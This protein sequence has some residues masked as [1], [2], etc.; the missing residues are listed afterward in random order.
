LIK[1]RKFFAGR[2]NYEPEHDS[3]SESQASTI[4]QDIEDVG[5]EPEKSPCPDM[6]LFK[7]IAHPEY[8]RALREPFHPASLPSQEQVASKL[9]QALGR[10]QVRL[11]YLLP[12]SDGSIIE[13][14]LITIPLSDL[15]PIDKTG[16][17][18]L[19]SYEALSYTWGDPRPTK[20]VICNGLLYPIVE[21]LHT[22]LL[23]LRRK[24]QRRVNVG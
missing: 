24:H 22:A 23:S 16:D 1:F 6:C 13:T 19:I 10:D 5:D 3:D 4:S 18:T 21:S 12:G 17:S 9:Y 11:L 7:I 20:A 8:Q 14:E 2:S 15:R